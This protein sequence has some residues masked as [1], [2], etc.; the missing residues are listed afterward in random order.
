M[1]PVLPGDQSKGLE[2]GE[3]MSQVLPGV[4]RVTHREGTVHSD[5]VLDGEEDE[6]IEPAV[7]VEGGRGE[8]A[9]DVS[10]GEGADNE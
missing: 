1:L 8:S 10:R 4:Q 7:L 3:Q 2:G 6:R 5:A 9:G